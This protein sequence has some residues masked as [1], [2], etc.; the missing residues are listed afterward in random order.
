MACPGDLGVVLR[1]RGGTLQAM[2]VLRLP[3]VAAWR[4]ALRALLCLLALAAAAGLA[5]ARAAQ[6]AQQA[7]PDAQALAA[8][9][10]ARF[11]RWIEPPV[12]QLWPP[13]L[14]E[15]EAGSG[16]RALI[17]QQ[18]GQ[19]VQAL[20]ALTADPAQ[21]AAARRALHRLA[22][23]GNAAPAEALLQAQAQALR[24]RGPGGAREAA[25]A[26]RHALALR[27]LPAA[28][29]LAMNPT[30]QAQ[31][32][33]EVRRTGLFGDSASD[34]ARNQAERGL[35]EAL[36]LDPTDAAA[37]LLW[38]ALP[39]RQPSAADW[40]QAL[41]AAQAS[42][43]WRLLAAVHDQAAQAWLRQGDA[44]AA[45]EAQAL[46]QQVLLQAQAQPLAGVTPR[47]AS[48]ALGRSA[49]WHAA[50]GDAAE[51][52]R[53]WRS[54]LA[55]RQR[56]ADTRRDDVALGL[57]LASAHRALALLPALDAQARQR[58]DLTSFQI[59]ESLAARDRYKPSTDEASWAGMATTFVVFASLATLLGGL[60]LLLMYRWRVGRW[61][62]RAA[63]APVPVAAAGWGV[64]AATVQLRSA[65]AAVSG[66]VADV[67]W[68]ASAVHLLA[69]VALASVAAWLSLDFGDIAITPLRFAVV[70]WA[71]LLGTG[72]LLWLLWA[73]ER[74]VQWALLA[75]YLGG[76]ALLCLLAGLRGTPAMAL[77]GITVPGWATLLVF[78]GMAAL[79]YLLLVLLLNR[80]VR[81]VGPVL[82]LAVVLACL[83]GVVAQV[84]SSSYAGMRGMAALA[85]E[86][87]LSFV[88]M[89]L[90][91]FLAG[92]LAALPLVALAAWALHV[93]DRRGWINDVSL[94]ADTVWLFQALVLCKSLAFDVGR[95]GVLGLLAFAAA[96]AVALAGGLLLRWRAR[97]QPAR[98]LLL[99][100]VFGDRRRS[101]RLFDSLR[102]R[103]AWAGP[104]RMIA[105]PDLA[106][107]TLGPAELID[108][109]TF[110]LRRHFLIEP[111]QVA[112][113]LAAL[114]DA[115]DLGGLYTVDELFCGNDAW[116][117]AVRALM[118][119]S[120]LVV[121][122]L[123]SFNADRLG[124]RYELGALL[125]TVP[126]SRVLLLVDGSTVLPLLE[127]TLAEHARA[128]PPGSP[129]LP[130]PATFTLLQAAPDDA[131]TV[132]AVMAIA[133][134]MPAAGAT[135][136]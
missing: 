15:R 124:C 58:H 112:P 113:R 108:F 55:Q 27:E 119:A 1:H 84:A 60:V 34:P 66:P 83:G 37:W 11:A 63:S 64:Q 14:A 127:G 59:Y 70:G 85:S 26:R 36:Q 118:Q 73:G 104:V 135:R 75:G 33:L 94:L 7:D 101:E 134:T 136:R 126:A 6:A 19:A 21:A 41:A 16:L 45:R 18:H 102:A 46:A 25:A 67:R 96:K 39:Q 123:R 86:W 31:P 56:L 22:R 76:L 132:R 93:A 5:G 20:L 53:L 43:D 115:P 91:I 92:A 74:R 78:W 89:Q 17:Q 87:G 97:R 44:A 9:A 80:Q 100:R 4:L 105:A 99:L 61:M 111:A 62:A 49:A 82:M 32:M 95:D 129:N 35:R 38:V 23:V 109:V 130:G 42:G 116:Q 2:C 30:G 12:V 122:D 65:V 110:R 54:V 40:Q 81:S 117:P 106:G 68:A 47:D 128:L 72:V 69:G 131:D 121:M 114:S 48:L 52:A 57:D 10:Q 133:R 50:A 24:Q 3:V 103:W 88:V 29:W 120:D 77:A 98:R 8:Q 13:G 79:P 107:R 28:F 51:A 71:Y 125:D 90:G